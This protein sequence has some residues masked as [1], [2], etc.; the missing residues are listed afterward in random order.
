M[1][2]IK[3]A[4]RGRGV[5]LLFGAGAAI[6]QTRQETAAPPVAKLALPAKPARLRAGRTPTARPG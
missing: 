2:A 6:G 4:D 1:R 3:G 5:A